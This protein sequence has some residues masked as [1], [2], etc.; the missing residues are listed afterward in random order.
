MAFHSM[1]QAKML[2]ESLWSGKLLREFIRM[3]EKSNEDEIAGLTVWI[4]DTSE[5]D[6]GYKHDACPD[7]G[8][9]W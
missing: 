9:S 2:S 5:H 7:A 4:V 1:R 3:Q 8:C 6:R